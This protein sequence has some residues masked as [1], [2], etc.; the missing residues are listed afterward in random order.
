MPSPCNVPLSP[1][2]P[3]NSN[4]HYMFS[5]SAINTHYLENNRIAVSA[6]HPNCLSTS[7]SS[8]MSPGPVLPLCSVNKC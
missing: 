4:Y 3:D 7:L 8:Q 2:N 6:K 1:S 5:R